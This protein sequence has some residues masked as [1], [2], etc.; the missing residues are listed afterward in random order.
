MDKMLHL[1]EDVSDV[2]PI[3]GVSVGRWDD[4]TTWR[5]DFREDATEA[6]KNAAVAM[7]AAWQDGPDANDVI[8]ERRRRLSVGLD[9]DFG[10]ARGTH[11]I[12][13]SDDDMRGWR[14]VTDYAN[15][16]IDIGNTTTTINIVTDTGPASVTAPEWQAVI[17]AAAQWR[18]AIWARSF[19]LQAMSPIP[20]NYADDSRWS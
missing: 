6:Q 7:L 5:I 20:S 11:H 15:A 18:Q 4:R 17:L 3:D 16:L 12:G 9:Y 10:D 13:T 1:V 8:S 19:E 14:E 2:A